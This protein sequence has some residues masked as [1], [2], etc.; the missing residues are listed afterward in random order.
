[1]RPDFV[2]THVNA[3][4][5]A[6]ICARLDGMPLA[7]ELA[8]ARIRA[9]TPEQIATRLDD[10]FRLLAAGSRTAPQRQQTLEAAIDWSYRLLSAPEQ[11]LFRRL[12]VFAGG[13]TLEAAEA[14][15]RGRIDRPRC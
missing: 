9:L 11:A 4:A 6:Q 15:G 1:V 7:I 14:S 10:R 8:A 5:V 3:P 2:I 12:S 13:W